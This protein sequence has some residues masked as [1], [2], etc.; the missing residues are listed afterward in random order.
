[1][2]QSRRRVQHGARASPPNGH[3]SRRAQSTVKRRGRAAVHPIQAAGRGLDEGRRAWVWVEDLARCRSRH[4]FEGRRGARRAHIGKA[5]AACRC[6]PRARG[7]AGRRRPRQAWWIAR[8]RQCQGQ[9]KRARRQELQPRRRG[10]FASR[11]DGGTSRK[12]RGGSD[13]DEVPLL[14]E[15]ARSCSDIVECLA[16][17]LSGSPSDSAI[18]CDVH[19]RVH[20]KVVR[21]KCRQQRCHSTHGRW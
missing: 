15:R 8:Q 7:G 4:S 16:S 19:G 17:G 6:R 21:A 2:W 1:M 20:S 11:G 12:R 14:A 18:L 5:L 9:R 10:H 3:N 13:S